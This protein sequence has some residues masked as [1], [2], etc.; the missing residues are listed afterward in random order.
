M[1]CASLGTSEEAAPWELPTPPAAATSSFEIDV[2]GGGCAAD[3]EVLGQV[4]VEETTET[5][6]ITATIRK[7]AV[8]GSGVCPDIGRLHRASVELDAPLGERRLLDGSTGAPP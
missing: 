4:S 3:E 1:A 2:L 5:V 7:P 8:S 6:T